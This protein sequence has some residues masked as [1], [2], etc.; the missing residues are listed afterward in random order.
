M[1]NF[2]SPLRCLGYNAADPH[3]GT[4]LQAVDRR[5]SNARYLPG[6]ISL[7]LGYSLVMRITGE[8]WLAPDHPALVR[9]VVTE[10]ADLDL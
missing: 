2:A 9:G 3:C 8:F 5:I 10:Q 4:G 1:L 7:R 6:S